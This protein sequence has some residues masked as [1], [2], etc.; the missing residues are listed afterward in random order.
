MSGLCV[1]AA[2]P[3]LSLCRK[4]RCL[5]PDP[6]GH[7]TWHGTVDSGSYY[8][9]RPDVTLLDEGRTYLAAGIT[10]CSECNARLT[11]GHAVGCSLK[12][13]H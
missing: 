2:I 6:D 12:D 7:T 3:G 9:G 1:P 11:R 5:T 10:Y 8:P 13:A 4:C